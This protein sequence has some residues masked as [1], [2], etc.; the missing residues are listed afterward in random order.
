MCVVERE[1]V[2]DFLFHDNENRHLLADSKDINSTSMRFHVSC[3]SYSSHNEATT[4]AT[5]LYGTLSSF[6]LVTSTR[7]P[8]TTQTP[9]ASFMSLISPLQSLSVYTTC[10]WTHH[11][12]KV[13]KV[14]HIYINVGVDFAET[15]TS[16]QIHK[17]VS[18]I[19]FQLFTLDNHTRQQQYLDEQCTRAPLDPD[20]ALQPKNTCSG[21]K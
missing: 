3:S 6:V 11:R 5:S 17:G 19:P 2:L 7:F 14:Q 10:C 16:Q 20:P 4:V 8:P 13:V 21:G 1:T 18:L 9:S 12:V 15:S